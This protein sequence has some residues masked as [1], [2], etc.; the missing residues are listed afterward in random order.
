MPKIWMQFVDS[1][2]TQPCGWSWG[3]QASET[4]PNQAQ[5]DTSDARYVA[6]Y[7]A[8]IPSVR[9]MSPTPDATQV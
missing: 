2:M 9:D 7:G 5:V 3:E 8:M 6:Y 4:W 1:A